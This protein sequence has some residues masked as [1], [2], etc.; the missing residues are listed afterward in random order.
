MSLEEK[1]EAKKA[2]KDRKAKKALQTA[3]KADSRKAASLKAADALAGLGPSPKK[4]KDKDSRVKNHP[5]FTEVD[6]ILRNFA[7]Y[8]D[9]GLSSS[10]SS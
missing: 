3:A 9:L 5:L 2:S 7:E 6:E 1:A 4:V 8:M 10:D